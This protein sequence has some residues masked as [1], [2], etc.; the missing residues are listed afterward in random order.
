MYAEWQCLRLPFSEWGEKNRRCGHNTS[1]FAM[2][3]HPTPDVRSLPILRSEVPRLLG[4]IL[5]REI[6]E[7]ENP[8]RAS[9]AGWDSLKHIELVFLLEDHF[10]VR[11]AEQEIAA[12]EDARGIECLVEAHLLHARLLNQ[13][14][15]ERGAACGLI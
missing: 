10:G 12:L 15:G 14:L 7:D 9:E 8:S 1:D 13:E 2:A 3:P 11:F 5:R 4:F 6:A